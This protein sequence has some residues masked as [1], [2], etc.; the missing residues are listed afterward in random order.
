MFISPAFAQTVDGA[1]ETASASGGLGAM[2]LQFILVIAIVY[3]LLIRPQQKRL[4]QH[5]AE[6][7]AIIKG[8][9]VVIS[10]II[11]TVVD[12]PT[13]DK[14][15]VDIGKGVLVTVLRG[16]VSQVLIDKPVQKKKSL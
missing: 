4:R 15:T 10:G 1:V 5:E 14:L 3:V 2:A 8:T 13:A 16:Y 12:V 6:L 9:K 7:N 11:G